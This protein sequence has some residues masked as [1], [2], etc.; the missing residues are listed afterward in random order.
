MPGLG[1]EG[2]PHPAFLDILHGRHYDSAGIM[3]PFDEDAYSISAFILHGI[4]HQNA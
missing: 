1:P 3:A 2:D 4:A